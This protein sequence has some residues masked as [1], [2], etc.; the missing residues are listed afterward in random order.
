MA[1][2]SNDLEGHWKAFAGHDVHE[3]SLWGGQF[4]NTIHLLLQYLLKI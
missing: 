4:N 1:H 2:I 3:G